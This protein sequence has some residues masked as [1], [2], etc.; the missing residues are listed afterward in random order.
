[1][2]QA[3]R[4]ELAQNFDRRR[5]LAGAVI[6]DARIERLAA[7]HRLIE[8]A[9]GFLDRR[10]RVGPVRVEDVHVLQAHAFQAL[11]QAGQQILARSP[12][13]VRARPHIVAGLG[14]DDQLIADTA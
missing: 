11:V 3:G 2:N 8:R 10:L 12:V 4:A 9:H 6:R 1:M 13:A 5:G 14:A 7:A